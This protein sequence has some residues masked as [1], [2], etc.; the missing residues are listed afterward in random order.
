MNEIKNKF[1]K[2]KFELE[3]NVANINDVY[4]NQNGKKILRFDFPGG[5]F[6]CGG[7]R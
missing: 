3:G 5:V 2:N 4:I 6:I 7:L 1:I